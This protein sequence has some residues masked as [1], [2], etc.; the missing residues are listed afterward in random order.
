M[1]LPNFAKT[2]NSSKRFRREARAAAR[3]DDPHVVPIYDV[4]EID[5]RLYVTMRLIDGVDLH[6]LL[7]TVRSSAATRGHIIEQIAVGTARRSPDGTGAPRRQTVQH[8]VGRQ[9][10]R[11]PHR[12]RHRPRRG[13]TALTSD[14]STI[15]TWAY[16]APERFSAGADRTQLRHLRAGL[17]ALP[18]PHRPTALPRLTPSSRSRVGHMV[19]P[20]PRPSEVSRHRSDQRWTG[21]RH[22]PGQTAT[23]RYPSAVEMAAAARQAITEPA[24][25]PD[26]GSNTTAHGRAT[27]APS[28]PAPPQPMHG[29]ARP[30]RRTGMSPSRPRSSARPI[31]MCHR[32]RTIRSARGDATACLVGAVVFIVTL[33]VAPVWSQSWSSLGAT[34]PP[35]PRHPRRRVGVNSPAPT[36]ADY[37]PGTDLED[38]TVPNAPATTS[39]WAVRST[40][41]ASGCVA[42]AANISDGGMALLVESDIRSVG[43][44]LGGRGP[45]LGAM[46]RRQTRRAL[47]GVHAATASRRHTLRRNRQGL[48]QRRLRRQ[49][50]REIHPHRRP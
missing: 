20:P 3:L 42:T 21:D 14:R 11:L 36:R 8:S 39:S 41:G 16:M 25:Q 1:L 23:D 13:G 37:G 12:L 30:R 22:R 48:H 19:A 33:I 46:R 5:G 2:P 32:R 27:A 44:H 9:R 6:T 7:K 26:N 47:G 38:K 18:M 15:G 17:R 29:A 24:S 28:S 10:L 31:C 50:N 35:Q 43:R 49:T 40:C 45:R 34:S 4:G